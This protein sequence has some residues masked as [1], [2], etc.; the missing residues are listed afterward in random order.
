MWFPPTR[1]GKKWPAGM[2][3]FYKDPEKHPLMTPTGKLEIYSQKLAN[4]FPDDD[5]RPPDPQWVEKSDFHDERIR[6]R[7]G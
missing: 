5:E 1:T 3:E 2:F 7:E 4:A 6:A